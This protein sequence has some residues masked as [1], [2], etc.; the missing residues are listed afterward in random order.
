M[1][2]S[3]SRARSKDTP[4]TVGTESTQHVPKS[5]AFEVYD[6]GRRSTESSELGYGHLT[7]TEHASWARQGAGPT[8]MEPSRLCANC[9]RALLASRELPYEITKSASKVT[10]AT[11]MSGQTRESLPAGFSSESVWKR[12]ARRTPM[13]RASS[14]CQ[15]R[16]TRGHKMRGP[17]DGG[18][19]F[20]VR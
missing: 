1:L 9:L 5:T 17:P 20:S 13:Q 2:A 4:D 16:R 14:G 15:V 10:A 8:L 19:R 6:L 3:P 11:H 7:Q 18:S 12:Y